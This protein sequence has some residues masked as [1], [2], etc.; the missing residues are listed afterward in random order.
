MGSLNIIVV[1][2]NAG[3]TLF[4][5]L[6]T[7]FSSTLE[8]SRYKVYVVDNNS[9]DNSINMIDGLSTNLT[10]IKNEINIGFGAACNIVMKNYPSD[11]VLLVN[12]DVFL[13]KET[14]SESLIFLENNQEIDVLGVKNYNLNNTVVPSCARFPTVGRFLNDSLGLSKIAPKIFIPGTIMTDWDHK[15]SRKVDHV[16]G[17][18]MMIRSS[19]LNKAGFFDDRFFLYLEDL[20]LSKRIVEN[21]GTIFYNSDISLIHEGGGTT[22]SIKADQLFYSLRSR[23]IYCKKYFNK[24][25]VWIITA[26]SVIIEPVSRSILLTLNLDFKGFSHLFKAYRKYIDWLIEQ[27]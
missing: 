4:K 22:K 14:L 26:S 24:L 11:F 5:C 17:A 27:K 12:P 9:S 23:I 10:V 15:T 13:K 18:Y 19:I 20:D 2:W 1:N 6:Q 7:V 8:K 3:P 16:I 21:G 25:S